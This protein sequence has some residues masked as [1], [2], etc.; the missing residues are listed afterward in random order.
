MA[1]PNDMVDQLNELVKTDGP[2]PPDAILAIKK[3]F[4][5]NW[6]PE[7]QEFNKVPANHRAPKWFK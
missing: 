7:K 6:N 2:P 3:M 1:T 5:F 4:G